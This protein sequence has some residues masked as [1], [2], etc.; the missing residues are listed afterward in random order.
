MSTES[1]K[2]F[3]RCALLF[4]LIEPFCLTIFIRFGLSTGSPMFSSLIEVIAV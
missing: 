2:L 3:G 4:V 1:I